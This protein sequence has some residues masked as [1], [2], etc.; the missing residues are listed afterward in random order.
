MSRNDGGM[1]RMLQQRTTDTARFT[2]ECSTQIGPELFALYFQGQESNMQFSMV[3][4]ICF[5]Q[6]VCQTIF[7]TAKFNSYNDCIG[8]ANG[9][10]RYMMETYPTSK[11]EVKRLLGAFE[12]NSGTPVVITDSSKGLEVSLV[13]TD[14][15]YALNLSDDG[16]TIEA[17]GSAP[18]KP[19]FTVF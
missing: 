5:A 19:V 18:F 2:L 16:S 7:D 15:G 12:A 3:M 9:V 14:S 13:V 1:K 4:I 11:G 6:G 8:A 17:F 10:V